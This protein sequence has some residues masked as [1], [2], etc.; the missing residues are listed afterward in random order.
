MLEPLDVLHVFAFDGLQIVGR[1]ERMPERHIG[2]MDADHGIGMAA[3]DVFGDRAAP[4]AAVRAEALVA[5]HLG[6]ER[7]PDVVDTEE[8]ARVAVLV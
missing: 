2:Q 8:P 6:H 4:V 7:V 5:Q 3:C 1:L